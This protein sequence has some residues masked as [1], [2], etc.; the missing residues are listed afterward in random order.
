MP[1]VVG[2]SLRTAGK[3]YFFDPGAER[4]L[5]G[6]KVV[7]ETARGAEIGVVKVPPSEVGNERVMQPL[8]PV[9]R[10]ASTVDI[11]RSAANRKQEESAL[12]V[13]K[14]LV[15]K[16]NLPM[17]LIDAQY[18]LDSSHLLIH[19]LA[20]NRVDFRELVRELARELRTRIELRQVGVRDE[21]KLI[22]GFGICGRKLC[23]ASF[24]GDFA[25]VAISMAKD[26]GLALN[27]QKIS[28]SCGRLMCC[29][30]YECDQYRHEKAELPRMNTQVETPQGIG[31]VTKLNVLSHQVEVLLAD[32]PAPI[33]F[34]IEELN[35]AAIGN[36]HPCCSNSDSRCDAC[37]Q[38]PPGE[39]ASVVRQRPSSFLT[40]ETTLDKSNPVAIST[41]HTHGEVSP[42]DAPRQ[43]RRRKRASTA[44]S[45]SG[46]TTS[47]HPE[48][49]TLTTS[50]VQNE[51]PHRKRPR[52]RQPR[53]SGSDPVRPAV[54]VE[55]EKG[56]TDAA[57]A[58]VP[59]GRYRPRRRR[60]AKRPDIGSISNE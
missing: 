7:V 16:L 26:Q 20:D 1:V 15:A 59:S 3:I 38:T 53:P 5:L 31:K 24:L 9:I 35:R 48:C 41:S 21:A 17:R 4:F 23:C 37:Q 36:S 8:K 60:R 22:G 29:L 52:R 13:C 49:T 40:A 19:F 44:S 12:L 32:A 34:S 18:T 30:A 6:E 45:N 54:A 50:S 2:I 43:R 28:G 57:T 39:T 11:S 42:T 10:R 58:Q 56:A 55:I 51:A 46:S 14:R 33:W 47:V 25:P 27:P